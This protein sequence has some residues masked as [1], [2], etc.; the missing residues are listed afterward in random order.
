MPYGGGG[1]NGGVV[2]ADGRLVRAS[3]REHDDLFWALR[4]GGGNFGVV[5][6]FT[7]QTR[8]VASVIGGPMLWPLEQAGEVLE[9]YA[10]FIA[11]APDELNGFFA[12]LT[13]PPGPPFPTELHLEKMCGVVWCHTGSELEARAALDPVRRGSDPRST[14]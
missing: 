2:L 3:E 14:E 7:F 13:V 8:P 5:T 1:H 12:V 11:R 9:L 6:S 4:G 10:D